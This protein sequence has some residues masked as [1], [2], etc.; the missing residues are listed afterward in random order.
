MYECISE[1]EMAP[2][3]SENVF[4]PNY[5]VDITDFMDQKLELMKIYESEIGDPP[6]PRSLEN[7]KAL[8]HFRGA[9]AGVL[10]AESFQLLKYI[11][12]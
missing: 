6:F 1:T 2:A 7:I 5:F 8:A 12:K 9:S 11:D 3:L 10:F 4:L